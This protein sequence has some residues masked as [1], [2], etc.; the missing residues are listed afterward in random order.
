MV[1]AA[2]RR[3]FRA[4]SVTLPTWARQ[5]PERCLYMSNRSGK[6]EAHAWDRSTGEHRQ[7]TDRPQGTLQATVERG[8]ERVWWFDDSKGNEQG[9]WQTVPFGGGE[10]TPAVDE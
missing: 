10:S 6:F 7:L 1:E 3:R 4:P 9:I 5:A 8:G 2:W